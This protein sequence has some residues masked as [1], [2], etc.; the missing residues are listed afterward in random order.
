VLAQ[1]SPEVIVPA[2][3]TGWNAQRALAGAFPDAFG[4][5]SLGTRYEL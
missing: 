4:Q 2:H 3:C 1:F 5:N